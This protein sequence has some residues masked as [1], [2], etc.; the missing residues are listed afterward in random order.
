[1]TSPLTRVTLAGPRRRV[2][3][4]LPSDE[5]VGLLLPELLEITGHR[6]GADPC[7]HQLTLVDGRVV[8]PGASLRAAGVPDGAVVRVHPR[9]EAPP[10]AV[11]LDLVDEVADDLH[12][13]P[14]RW[15]PAARRW[16]ATAVVVLAVGAAVLLAPGASTPVA[17]L[18]VGVGLLLYGVALAA[19]ELRPIGVALV[20][21]GATAVSVTL[22][23]WTADAATRAVLAICVAGITGLAL[24]AATGRLRAGL[25]GAGALLAQLAAWVG[26][27]RSG[28]PVDRTATVMAVVTVAALGLLPR[29]ALVT[30]GLTRLDDQLVDGHR[31]AR[32]AAAA[33][34]D[35]AHRGLA[36]A[37]GVTAAS[38]GLAGWLLATADSTWTV[39]L[40]VALGAVLLLR[41]RAHP[42]TSEV[43]PLVGATLLVV[44]GLVHRF[45]P[46]SSWGGVAAAGAVA[47]LG[48]VVLG[49]RPPAHV[50]ARGRRLA[51]RVEALA[52]IAILPLAV[53][54]FGVYARLLEAF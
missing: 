21:A 20:F 45:L 35:A 43:V 16:T 13:R 39:L 9:A 25:F 40:A 27:L 6:P 41:L 22:P 18:V 44:A 19:A 12:R 29:L 32:V 30:S 53:G 5:A 24:G 23:F 47:G 54:V 17:A 48:L 34:I 10:A 52:V 37:V 33:A 2:D 14:G 1:M 50:M 28:V 4:A 38:G 7:G 8:D 49:Y 42:L 36:P 11:V 31:V 51:D 46:G 3:L 15:N 26:L